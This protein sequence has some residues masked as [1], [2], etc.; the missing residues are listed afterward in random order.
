[1]SERSDLLAEAAALVD[2]DR[3][4]TY[5]PPSADFARVAVMW[6]VLFGRDFSPHEVAMAMTCIKLSRLVHS[7]QKRDSWVDGAGYLACGWECV[8]ESSS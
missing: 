5:G 3:N 7:P 8:V 4:T 6:S 1:M 2:G